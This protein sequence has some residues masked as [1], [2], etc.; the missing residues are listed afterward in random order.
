MFVQKTVEI[1]RLHVA[2]KSTSSLF[3]KYLYSYSAFHNTHF[4]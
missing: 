1:K 3:C 2:N 4:A